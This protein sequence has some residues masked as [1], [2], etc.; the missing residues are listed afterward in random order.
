MRHRPAAMMINFIAMTKTG[1]N[2]G[3][4]YYGARYYDAKISLWL[5]VDLLAYK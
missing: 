3:N 1:V 4:Y 2:K 5:S